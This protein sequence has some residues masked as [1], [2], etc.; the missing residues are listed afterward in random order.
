MFVGF[1]ED[2][3]V[4]PVVDEPETVNKNSEPVF[5]DTGVG[6]LNTSVSDVTAVVGCNTATVLTPSVEDDT[7]NAIGFSKVYPSCPNTLT[8]VAVPASSK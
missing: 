5:S 4:V 2:E 8:I 1:N 6:P 7:C 3:Y